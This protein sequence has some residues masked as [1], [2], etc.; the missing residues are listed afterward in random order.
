MFRE[1]LV[2]LAFAPAAHSKCV[3]NQ[4]PCPFTCLQSSSK[5]ESITTTIT[6][7]T[8]EKGKRQRKSP[9]LINN[10]MKSKKEQ[11]DGPKTQTQSRSTRSRESKTSLLETNNSMSPTSTP[12][13]PIT[14]L[15]LGSK[16]S[17]TVI[18]MSPFG[19][20]VKINYDLKLNNKPGYA[21]LH[22]SQI[23]NEEVADD[24]STMFRVGQQV[25]NLRVIAV[26]YAKGEVGLS[27]RTPR[28]KRKPLSD[29]KV[30]QQISGKVATILE[31]GAFIDIGAKV[32]PLL[33]I[34]RI[35]QEKI[36][37]IRDVLSEGDVVSIR[38]I[39]LDET[40][41]SMSASMLSPDA[42]E[43]LNRRVRQKKRSI[44]RDDTIS[45][46]L[47]HQTE[48]ELFQDAIRDLEKTLGVVADKS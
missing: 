8:H 3:L 30:G 17:G 42:D 1:I 44:T 26:N 43:Y 39:D 33:H 4:Y 25:E 10:K 40:K 9:Q 45:D 34:S 12:L 32:N 6:T 48:I 11:R 31:Y 19:V 15:V 14:A 18:G 37:N 27:L 21:L 46:E 35:T 20:F 7:T 23:Q 2:I 13:R 36:E 5:T 29:F 24:L 38:I 41:K 16:I 22:K 47:T 28:P